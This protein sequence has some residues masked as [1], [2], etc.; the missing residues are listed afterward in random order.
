MTNLLVA[1]LGPVLWTA[2]VSAD[3]P[4]LWTLEFDPDF[5]GH[6]GSG[7]C[8]FKQDDQKLTC[9]CG[10]DSPKPTPVT[11]ELND[12]KVVFRFK[13]GQDNEISAT[14]QA[15][16]VATVRAIC[17]DTGHYGTV[18]FAVS[19]R[20]RE[21]GMRMAL[22]AS[23]GRILGNV[24]AQGFRDQDRARWHLGVDAGAGVNGGSRWAECH[25]SGGVSQRNADSRSDRTL[26]D[27]SPGS[28]RRS[29]ESSR[30][31]EDSV[32]ID[33]PERCPSNRRR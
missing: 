24:L 7:Q 11:G 8:T 31:A 1:L 10:S 19:S 28:S 21:I 2:F 12:Q 5:S 29:A 17:V 6:R 32:I 23:S 30:C 13:T 22:G 26:S 14:S 4:G 18:A 27:L 20:T 16:E 25:G 3:V 9:S 33:R 15:R